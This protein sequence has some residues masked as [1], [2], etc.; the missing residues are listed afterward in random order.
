MDRETQK[1]RDENLSFERKW[2][3]SDGR[4]ERE[5]CNFNARERERESERGGRRMIWDSPAK[6]MVEAKG[7]AGSEG[8]KGLEGWDKE[9]NVALRA[10]MCKMQFHQCFIHHAPLV[11]CM[12]M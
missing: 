11:F 9:V 1:L 6:A 3:G 5:G 7:L 8:E 2:S 4:V 12:L 10:A